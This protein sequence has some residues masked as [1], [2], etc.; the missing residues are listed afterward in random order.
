MKKTKHIRHFCSHHGVYVL[1]ILFF[2]VGSSALWGQKQMGFYHD[3]LYQL[4]K[5]DI[6]RAI[7]YGDSLL[8]VHAEPR[9]EIL[10]VLGSLNIDR[11][12]TKLAY[13]YFAQEKEI[14]EKSGNQVGLAYA[15]IRMGEASIYNQQKEQALSLL[16]EALN[17]AKNLG[18]QKLEARSYHFLG[19]IYSTLGDFEKSLDYTQKAAQLQVVLH[20][21]TGV[22]ETYNDIGTIFLKKGELDSAKYYIEKSLYINKKRGDLLPI[23]VNYSMLMH[24]YRKKGDL[25][26]AIFYNKKA[27]QLESKIK[28]NEPHLYLTLASM[29]FK[30]GKKQEAYKY[31]DIALL[32]AKNSN[33]VKAKEIVH[34]QRFKMAL[35]SGDYKKALFYQ[36]KADSLLRMLQKKENDEK[37][38]LINKQYGLEEK[39][40]LLQKELAINRRNKILFGTLSLLLLLLGISMMQ[41]N[42]NA[43]LKNQKERIALEQRILSSQ[44]NPHFVH[45]VLS[46]IQASLLKNDTLKSS[47]S[48]SQFAKLIRQN[49]EFVSKE[50]ISLEDD[51]DALKNYIDTQ[52]FRFNNQFDYEIHVDPDIDTQMVKIPP[53][54]LQPFVENAI[55]HGLKNLQ[56]KGLLKIDITKV[57]EKICF[58]ITDNGV[59]LKKNYPKG[60]RIHSLMIFKKR[61]HLINPNDYKS[62]SLSDETGETIAKFCL[63]L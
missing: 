5:E 20:D 12:Q 55:E 60:D 40:A 31:M 32:Q 50:K 59:G 34:R 35:Q 51:L 24:V 48:L 36:N 9:D 56:R 30:Q 58:K 23:M 45:N 19:L 46:A 21:T 57:D 29:L 3:K 22:S 14:H 62:F 15:L 63:S 7:V 18:N 17:I 1:L 38:A 16:M 42:K 13:T 43:K 25:E 61:V 52:R 37:L 6:N 39:E 8:D 2:L 44:M 11:H 47:D 27:L 53:L 41:I 10:H 28:T 26:K 4:A 33:R 49:F 54:L